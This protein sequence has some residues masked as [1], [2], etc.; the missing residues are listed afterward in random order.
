MIDDVS[1]A[2]AIESD[3]DKL[4]EHRARDSK[5]GR[6]RA[7]AEDEFR[8]AR[9]RRQTRARRLENARSWVEFFGAAA[10]RH[11]DLASLNAAKRDRVRELIKELEAGGGG[12]A[13]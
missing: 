8:K 1:R 6:S 12:A 4:I 7:N 3:L 11:H 2:E 10:L 5:S 13:P 9:D